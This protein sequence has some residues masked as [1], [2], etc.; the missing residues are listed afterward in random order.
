M[1][2]SGWTDEDSRVAAEKI[3]KRAEISK[4][5]FPILQVGGSFAPSEFGRRVRPIC[6][7]FSRILYEDANVRS[8]DG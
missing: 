8:L 6:R 7:S 2:A 4:V 5:E 1:M 3:I